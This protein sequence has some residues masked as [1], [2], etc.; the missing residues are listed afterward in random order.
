MKTILIS[1]A[2]VG[3][4]CGGWVAAA[5]PA[6]NSAG[7]P[8]APVWVDGLAVVGSVRVDPAARAVIATGWVNQVLGPIELL[9]CGPGGKT[10]ESVFVM[11]VNP[12]DLQTALLLLGLKPGTPPPA[13]GQGQP[14]GPKLD[15]W[16]EWADQ[17][18]QRKERAE[19]FVVNVEN[20]KPLPKTPWIFTGSVFEE[21]EFKALAEESLVATYLDPWAIVNLPLA[22][23]AN[24]EILTVNERLVPPVKTPVTFRIVAR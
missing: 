8:P 10:H 16:I 7:A 21:G 11:D 1:M 24:D 3:L 5:D 2:V 23:A 18:T 4:G 22:C 13:L 12:L 6:T 14:V 15:I 17:G 19:R 9:A 20:D